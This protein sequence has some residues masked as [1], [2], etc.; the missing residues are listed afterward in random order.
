MCHDHFIIAFRI[1]PLVMASVLSLFSLTE[2]HLTEKTR[3]PQVNMELDP[4]WDDFK[5]I[6]SSSTS[7]L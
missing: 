6:S 3:T 7:P 5:V 4:H 1:I 2:E